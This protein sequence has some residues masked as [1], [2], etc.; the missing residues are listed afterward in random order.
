MDRSI[1]NL[2]RALEKEQ[3]LKANLQVKKDENNE[4][5]TKLQTTK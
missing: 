1:Q 3:K 5:L 4:V 2:Q